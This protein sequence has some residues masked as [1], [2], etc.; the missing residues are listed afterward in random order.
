MGGVVRDTTR[1]RE[2]G[3]GAWFQPAGSVPTHNVPAAAAART[4]DRGGPL[5]GGPRPAIGE[6]GRGEKRGCVGQPGG[7]R[8]G[9][10]P[11][12]QGNFYLFK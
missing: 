1:R 8:S 4:G 11:Q 6:R 3:E 2:A 10:S 12:E 9:L 7:K 5:M